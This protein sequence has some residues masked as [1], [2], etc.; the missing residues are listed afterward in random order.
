MTRESEQMRAHES[1]SGAGSVT[2]DQLAIDSRTAALACAIDHVS[3]AAKPR[4]IYR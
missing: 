3:E 2:A 4:A 1:S